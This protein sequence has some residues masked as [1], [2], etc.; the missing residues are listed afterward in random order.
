[1]RTV[2]R[3]LTR[4]PAP[5]LATAL[6]AGLLLSGCGSV[7]YLAQSVSGHLAMLHA[8]RPVDAWLADSHTPA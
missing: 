5:T 2:M 1:M 3:S 4:R 6:L 8:A 7:D